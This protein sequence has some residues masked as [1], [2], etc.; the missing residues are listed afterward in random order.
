MTAFSA[1]FRKAFRSA[2]L[3]EVHRLMI[4]KGIR[5]HK[6]LEGYTTGW[7]S[8]ES[9]EEDNEEMETEDAQHT[10]RLAAERLRLM[11]M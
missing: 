2:E 11:P 8:E 6:R 4:E 1:P 3:N 10:Q 5:I 9:E 7:K